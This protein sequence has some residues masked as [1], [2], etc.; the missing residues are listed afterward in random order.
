MFLKVVV[1]LA[2][3]C[4]TVES[5]SLDGAPVDTTL[6]DQ[7]AWDAL[8]FAVDQY[9]RASHDMY[10]SKVSRVIRVQEQVVSGMKYIFTVEMARTPCWK[11]CIVE[12]CPIHSNPVL[13]RRHVCRLAV[14][15]RPWMKKTL[16]VENTC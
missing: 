14:W 5:S 2:V 11:G 9:N 15:S 8:Q 12:R 7:G 3:L 16:L 10:L 6:A 13:A 1:L 4:L